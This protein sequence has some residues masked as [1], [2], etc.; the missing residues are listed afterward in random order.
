MTGTTTAATGIEWVAAMLA[1]SKFAH[2]FV[3]AGLLA[4]LYRW[5]HRQAEL[6]GR[7]EPDRVRPRRRR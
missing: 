5:L 4:V 7:P 6:P 1:L 2:L 3:V